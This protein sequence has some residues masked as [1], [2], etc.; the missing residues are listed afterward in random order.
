LVSYLVVGLARS[1]TRRKFC[2]DTRPPF[3]ARTDHFWDLF[4]HH[5]QSCGRRL[6]RVFFGNVLGGWWM[7]WIL[8]L[9]FLS[10]AIWAL[11]PDKSEGAIEDGR[12][13]V[14]ARRSALLSRRW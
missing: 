4:R 6:G 12:L 11:V 7:R 3:Y 10:V 9:S 8:G 2:L 13:G 5:R 14:F 1:A